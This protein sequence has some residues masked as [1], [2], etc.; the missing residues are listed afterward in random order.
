MIVPVTEGIPTTS[1]NTT[2]GVKSASNS[3]L[4]FTRRTPR[5]HSHTYTFQLWITKISQDNM[6][7]GI[8]AQSAT[9]RHFYPRSYGPGDYQVVGIMPSQELYQELAVWIRLHQE[10]VINSFAINTTKLETRSVI[11]SSGLLTLK[12]P[13]EQINVVGWISYFSL[14]KTGVFAPAPEYEFSFTIARDQDSNNA[15]FSDQMS[16]IYGGKDIVDKKILKDWN[17]IKVNQ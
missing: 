15:K 12:I 6:L 5:G 11:D 17:K 1:K 8:T 7:S 9:T 2:Q 3:Y 14:I 10:Y 16:K 4:Q 13:S